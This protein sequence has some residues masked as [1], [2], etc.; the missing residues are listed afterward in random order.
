MSLAGAQSLQLERELFGPQGE[1]AQAQGGTLFLED[2]DEG[3]RKTHKRGLLDCFTL[4]SQAIVPMHASSCPHSAALRRSPRARQVY[5]NLFYRLN[6]VAIR[7]PPLRERLEDIP[8]VS[9]APRAR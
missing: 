6:V 8:G 9:R 1:F 4:K 7:M 2:I 3:C 5:P